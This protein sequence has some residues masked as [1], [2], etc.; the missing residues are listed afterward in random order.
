MPYVSEKIKIAGTKFD[1][2]CKLTPEQK[3]EILTLSATV[4]QRKLAIQ[5][6]VDRRTIGFILNPEKL[7]E[8]KKKR[9]E[10]GGAKIYYDKEKQTKTIR[11]HRQYKQDLKVKGLIK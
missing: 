2:R 6:H 4:S 1:K 5:F 7:E 3:A 11:K 8:N 10:R 9:D